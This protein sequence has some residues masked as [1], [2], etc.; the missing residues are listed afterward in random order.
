MV[1]GATTT[2]PQARWIHRPAID[3]IVGCG[4]WSAPLL[5]LAG[6]GSA[7]TRTWA[8]A[9]Y[10]LALAF[11]YP[12]F[13]A[14]VYRAYHKR[15]E[16]ARYRVFTLH[17]T[18]LLALVTVASHARPS[19]L[20]WLFT[21]Y[22]TWSPWHYTGQNY[23]LAM[24]FA[25]RNG[26]APTRRE[27]RALYG[28]FVASY[29]L[30]FVSFHT[31]PSTDPLIRSVGIPE[32]AA[33]L[34]RAVLLVVVFALGAVALVGLFRR[35]GPAAMLAT[36]TLVATQ[37]MWFVA[38][39][40][41]G[42]IVGTPAVQTRYSS[43]V[44][45]VMHSAQYL[46]IT[47]YYARREAEASPAG[48]WR[49]WVYS[50]TLLGGG[51]ALFIPGP[52]IASYLFRADF[53]QSVLIFTAIVNIHHF[54]LD[55][56]IWKLRD[57]R[58]AAVLVESGQPAAAGPVEPGS[59]VQHATRWLTGDARAA[60]ALRVVALFALIAWAAL[61]QARFV[62][63]TS[64]RDE[65]ALSRA[66]AL[67]PY[68]SSVQRRKARLLIEQGRYSEADAVYQR[69]LV[70]HPED[71]EALLN[72]GVLAN[73]LGRREDA[74]RRWTEALRTNAGRVNASRHLAEVWAA[75]ADD[76]DR[77]GRTAEAAEAFQRV[78]TLDEQSGDGAALGVDWFNYG[79]FL[80]RQHADAPVVLAS[81]L[82][83]EHLLTATSDERVAT[84]RVARAEVEHE[85]PEAMA[86]VRAAPAATLAAAR[87]LYKN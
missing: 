59:A 44:L 76:F 36:A 67:N 29:V 10:V 70:V 75:R 18:A 79:Q 68:D 17:I 1:A 37:F 53:T 6:R 57:R 22:L 80:R 30:L 74:V 4:A 78:L 3:L 34:A 52:W 83:A 81:L 65:T 19:L 33:A 86:I 20:P 26:T 2:A 49:P 15:T 25:R 43:G 12:H 46:W 11:N 16:F 77:A 54:I 64:E 42:W 35:A 50:A 24:M 23:G 63:G 82:Q 39:A 5:L 73:T 31:G 45:A 27:E 32:A 14:T 72:A 41:A 62:L 51:I 71:G 7:G 60:R 47:S 9:F 85:R 13:M 87:A 69:Y 8:V 38:P 66:E 61:D 21:L 28:A 55:G 56:A 58:V 40:I 48:R 84:V